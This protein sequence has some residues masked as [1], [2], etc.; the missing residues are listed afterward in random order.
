[1]GIGVVWQEDELLVVFLFES[2]T[3]NI[4]LVDIVIFGEIIVVREADGVSTW[5]P[6]AIALLSG[7]KYAVIGYIL[8]VSAKNE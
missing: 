8:L 5:N 1:M 7:R 6:G 2:Q 3:E 4:G